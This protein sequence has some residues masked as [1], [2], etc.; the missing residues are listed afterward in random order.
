MKTPKLK[1]SVMAGYAAPTGSA[2]VRVRRMH[3]ID[4]GPNQC[5]GP[6][7]VA[8]YRC[9]CGHESDWETADTLAEIRRGVPCP[10]C[11]VEPPNP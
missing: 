4:A 3:M 6:A 7:H 8:K 5:V 10:V 1:Q 9:K 2:A 11:N